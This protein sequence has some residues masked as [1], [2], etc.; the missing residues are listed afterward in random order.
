MLARGVMSG[1]NQ[2]L[3]AAAPIR[4]RRRK[5]FKKKRPA[6]PKY[7]LVGLLVAIFFAMVV[8]I[9]GQNLALVNP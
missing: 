5:W 8:Y 4:H 1:P 2:N 7:V 6:W 3:M 9:V